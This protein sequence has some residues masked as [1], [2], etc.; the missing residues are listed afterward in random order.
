MASCKYGC[1][2]FNNVCKYGLAVTTGTC[3]VNMMMC[4]RCLQLQRTLCRSQVER[5]RVEQ[6]T[7]V[8]KRDHQFQEWSRFDSQ[9][10]CQVLSPSHAQST[11]T[12]QCGFVP[13][14]EVVYEV[15]NDGSWGL[16]WGNETFGPRICLSDFWT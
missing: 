1:C 2:V 9:G 7:C 10:V 12:S 13:A 15:T 3:W 6:A 16:P 8:R 5:S 4:S 11:L 14:L